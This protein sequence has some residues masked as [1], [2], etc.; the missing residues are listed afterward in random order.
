[1][2]KIVSFLTLILLTFNTLAQVGVSTTS[3]QA[4]LDIT[5]TTNGVLI[6]RVT[7][8]SATDNTTVVSPNSADLVESTL[9]YNTGAN[10]AFPDAGYYY[11]TGAQWDKMVTKSQRNFYM[12]TMLINSAGVQTETGIGFEPSIVEF[13]AVNRVQDYNEGAQ[14]S[15]NNNSNDIRMAG[16]FTTGFARNDNGSIVQ[17]AISYGASGSSINNIGTYAST[18]HCLAAY[19]VDSNGGA[20]RDNGTTSGGTNAENGLIS[21]SFTNFDTDGFRINVDK[22]LSPAAGT[23]D[24]TNAIVVIYKAYR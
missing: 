8:A 7:L 10:G 11:W 5:S 14:K 20:L 23:P 6:P 16:G 21:A 18:S 2:F 15:A 22:F 24:R 17:Q 12:G 4:A 1:M 19:F 13:I 9:V 3:P